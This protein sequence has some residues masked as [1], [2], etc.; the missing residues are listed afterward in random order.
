MFLEEL[1]G[2]I[3]LQRMKR[4]LRQQDL[5]NALNVSPQAVSK[6]ERGENAPDILLLT[7]LGG[8]LGVTVDWLLGSYEESRDVFEAT[9]LV[10]SVS[11]A[12]E[13]SL[14]V[15]P[16]DYARWANGVF[17][18]LTN[19]TLQNSGV[20]IKYMGDN[21]L[22]FFSGM[23]HRD[24]AM[25]TVFDAISIIPDS[26]KIGLDSG[27]IYLGSVGHPDYSRPDIMGEAVNIAFLVLTWA[28]SNVESGIA[29]TGSVLHGLRAMANQISVEREE[30]VNF[31][32]VP[33]PVQVFEL[34]EKRKHR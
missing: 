34:T 27:K 25:K 3:R 6:W 11:G 23:D 31:R 9:I 32:D 24:R 28:D 7:S 18:Q 20:P 26:L 4:G 12:Y 1:G 2:R 29:A 5:A 19:V 15:R 14:K 10:S 8:L 22:C 17:F 21:Y 13:R 16:S 33:A 30:D